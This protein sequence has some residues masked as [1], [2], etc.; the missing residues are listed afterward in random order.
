MSTELRHKRKRK[1]CSAPEIE[2]P[3][4]TRSHESP[5]QRRAMSSGAVYGL[6]MDSRLVVADAA[7]TKL[8]AWLSVSTFAGLLAFALVG[9]TW[10]DPAGFVI[11][12][13]AREGRQHGRVSRSA[14][15]TA[16]LVRPT[17]NRRRARAPTDAHDRFRS[18]PTPPAG[19]RRTG[20]WQDPPLRRAW[21]Q[22]HG[23]LSAP[24]RRICRSACSHPPLSLALPLGD[25]LRRS[26]RSG[27]RPS[28]RTPSTT[29]RSS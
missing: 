24:C 1:R 7:E 12:A 18:G 29:R 3:H 14:T 16:R 8:C 13:F 22:G 27:R 19:L 15:T 21:R 20:L 28:T 11:A 2:Y 5:V 6:E 26:S 25:P 17:P 23:V 10:I 4:P 9:W